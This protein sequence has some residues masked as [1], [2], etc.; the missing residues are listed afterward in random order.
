VN[1][2]P[3]NDLVVIQR[4]DEPIESKIG[5]IIVPQI[6]QEKGS[7]GR[8]V[9]TGPGKWILGEWRAMGG[10]WA[11]DKNGI[12]WRYSYHYEWFPG[13]FR[14]MSFHTGDVVLFNSKW[15]ELSGSHYDEDTPVKYDQGLHLVMEADIFCKLDENRSN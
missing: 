12:Q 2:E 4:I 10:F 11:A 6:A 5:S 1:I 15:S 8:I 7:R 13:Y 14:P 3:R 9:G